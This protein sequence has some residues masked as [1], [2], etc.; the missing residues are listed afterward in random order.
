MRFLKW[1]R[2]NDLAVSTNIDDR[3]REPKGSYWQMLMN[4][5]NGPKE[6]VQMKLD[7]KSK[8]AKDLGIDDVD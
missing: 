1:M 2:L 6:D 4:W 3:R 8:L 5:W 7:P